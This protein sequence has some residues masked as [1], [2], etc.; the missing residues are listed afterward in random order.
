LV[1]INQKARA[2]KDGDETAT[3]E[4]V[5]QMFLSLDLAQQFAG[6]VGRRRGS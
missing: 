5:D 2:A 6:S 1:K 4:L 3:R